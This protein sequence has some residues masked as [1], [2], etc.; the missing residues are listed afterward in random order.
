MP[1]TVETRCSY[2]KQ[3]KDDCTQL[4]IK[5][6]CRLKEQAEESRSRSDSS[7]AASTNQGV[8][9]RAK[10][11]TDCSCAIRKKR[12]GFRVYST[13]LPFPRQH[14]PVENGRNRGV[15]NNQ[16]RESS[17]KIIDLRVYR[18]RRVRVR[19]SGRKRGGAL[20]FENGVQTLM[21]LLSCTRK[22]TKNL[23]SNDHARSR[24]TPFCAKRT[25]ST[26][27][28]LP[29]ELKMDDFGLGHSKR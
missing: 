19:M 24:L 3:G 26:Y 17:E 5:L 27:A 29:F 14:V 7:R 23:F 21:V 8:P 22:G 11:N 2:G 28:S 18:R 9:Y 1:K 25:V 6:A 13:D 20:L 4:N 12:A 10:I 16:R 15:T